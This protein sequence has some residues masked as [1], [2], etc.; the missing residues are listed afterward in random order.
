MISVNFKIMIYEPI[1]NVDFLEMENIKSHQT[2][3]SAAITRF[4]SIDEMRKLKN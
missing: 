3:N 2:R 1:T 4:L